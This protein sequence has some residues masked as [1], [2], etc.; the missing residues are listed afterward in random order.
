VRGPQAWRDFIKD[1]FSLLPLL[2]SL[3]PLSLLPPLPLLSLCT[4]RCSSI[5]S[6][7]GAWKAGWQTP[8]AVNSSC[9]R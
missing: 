6:G 9:A 1:A 7:Y 4:R 3:L 2:F 5:N 8:T